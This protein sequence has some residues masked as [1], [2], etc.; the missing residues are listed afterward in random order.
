VTRTSGFY[1][2]VGRVM[3]ESVTSK[4][5]TAGSEYTLK[6]L[7]S[8][9]ANWMLIAEI[10]E[11]ADL[12]GV[13]VK[14][15]G[16][17]FRRIASAPYAQAVDVMFRELAT[18]PYL[19][20]VHEEVVTPRDPALEPGTSEKP[21]TDGDGAGD[22]GEDDEYSWM[23][24]LDSDGDEWNDDIARGYFGTVPKNIRD[25]AQRRFEAHGLTLT[26][27]KRNAE[28]SIFASAF[29]EDTLNNLLF[30]IYVP[31]G[32]LYEDELAKML[33][34]FHD[35]LGSVKGQ[36]V[37]QS[38]YRTPRGRVI[39]FFGE[40]G[41]NVDM[42][43]D[44]L[45]E[46]AQF[47]G[48]VEDSATAEQMLL[49][50]GV[51]PDRASGLVSR[52]ARAARRVLVDTKHTRE[53]MILDIQQQLESELVDDL[54]DVSTSELGDLVR[55]LVPVSPFAASPE[56]RSLAAGQDAPPPTVNV[57]IFH[58]VEGIVAQNVNGPVTVGTPVAEL[59]ELV[60][61]FGDDSA[62]SLE[63][64]AREL[65]DP[66]APQPARLRARQVLKNFLLRNASRIEKSV[67]DSALKW[68]VDSVSGWLG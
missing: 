6:S 65:A 57:Q 27:Y 13:I 25:A 43:S 22:E 19:L 48:I 4:I 7:N 67:Y 14:L 31:A 17:D 29:V 52:Y 2:G 63:T 58:R 11:R 15:T 46:F 3:T 21:S 20:L 42:V 33:E 62:E 38:G 40:A 8:K 36:T 66:E 5:H 54:P 41:M 28:A 61:Q 23:D 1:L 16:K 45:Q 47:L 10:I 9:P 35:W 39:E 50:L 26:T 30:R 51:P 24:E 60:R 68:V 44:E 18:K 59:I 37:R 12:T 49:R 64:S 32:R 55:Q 34:L 53:R 56:T